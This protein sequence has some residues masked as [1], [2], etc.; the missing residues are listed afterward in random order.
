MDGAR[1]QSPQEHD[2]IG[3][4]ARSYDSCEPDL[5]RPSECWVFLGRANNPAHNTRLG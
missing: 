3:G 1:N 4:K 5:H 2:W